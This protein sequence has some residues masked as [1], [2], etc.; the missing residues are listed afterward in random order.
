M[1]TKEIEDL[2]IDEVNNGVKVSV[3]RRKVLK[4]FNKWYPR[5]TFYKLVKRLK[6]KYES[7]NEDDFDK[8]LIK[9][10]AQK[11]RLQDKNRLANKLVREQC[12]LANANQELFKEL[13]KKLPKLKNFNPIRDKF[14]IKKM[15]KTAIIQLSDLH[16]NEVVI[17]SDTIGLNVH[18]YEIASKRLWKYA[19]KIKETLGD[20]VDYILVALTG[21]ILNSD[22]RP[23]EVLTN[24]G[25]RSEALL[26]AV[27][28]LSS[29]LID[30]GEDYQ[31]GV[32]SVIGNESRLDPD[33]VWS[34][35]THNYDFLIHRMLSDMF[36]NYRLS[37]DF[38]EIKRSY[39][40]VINLCGANI[41]MTHGHTKLDWKKAVEKYN[42][43]GVILNY[44]ISGHNH[45]VEINDKN[46]K[47]ASTVGSN[48]YST[49]SLNVVGRA[50]QNIYIIEKEMG[51]KYPVITPIIID[52]QNTEGCGMYSYSKDICK[53]GMRKSLK[54]RGTDNIIIKIL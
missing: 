7:N 34:C 28:I 46:S 26:Y 53:S 52:L 14:D 33:I 43:V 39:E 45:S 36:V 19:K 20:K 3:I 16:L 18:N 49:F 17:E 6:K 10:Q 54:K 51:S 44:M 35:P 8:D 9:L 29:F 2:V 48:F 25:N 30:L 5:S 38:F 13:L 31:I 23:D 21:D 22:R 4:D 24:A 37:I 50:S 11:Q 27:Q 40:T 41:L 1:F 12:R 15:E 32:V 42:E 47:C